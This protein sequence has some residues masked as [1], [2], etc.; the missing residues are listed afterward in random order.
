MGSRSRRDLARTIGRIAE[1]LAHMQDEVHLIE[2][3]C[4]Q[5]WDCH[6]PLPMLVYESIRYRRNKADKLYPEAN[7]E[8]IPEQR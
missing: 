8:T 4:T 2:G 6:Q 7:K 5:M 3:R 1:E